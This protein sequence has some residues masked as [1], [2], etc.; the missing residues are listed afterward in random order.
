MPTLMEQFA[1]ATVDLRAAVASVLGLEARVNAK[2]DA[3]TN[4]VTTIINQFISRPAS[5]NVFCDP[6]NGNDANDGTTPDKAKRSAD[7]IL[8]A[9]TGPSGV[10]LLMLDDVVLRNRSSVAGPLDL[11]GAQ[12]ANNAFGYTF[13]RRTVRFLGTA[14]NSPIAGPL[15]GSSAASG[16]FLS[17]PRMST[18][19]VSFLLPDQPAGQIYSEHI[20]ASAAQLAFID[21]GVSVLGSNAGSLIGAPN[22]RV[23]VNGTFTL[24][25][26]AAGHL[27]KGIAAGAN[28]NSMFNYETNVTSG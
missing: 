10:A 23:S 2:F 22:G 11:Y 26:G 17:G 15:G 3:N 14:D 18:A 28:P 1:Q 6:V 8:G 25:A 24:G 9:M 7:A 13:T 20:T 4:N 5:I 16:I 21:C 27:F 19:Y 12:R